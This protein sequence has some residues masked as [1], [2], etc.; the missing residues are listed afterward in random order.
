MRMTVLNYI[1]FAIAAIIVVYE[2]ILAWRRHQRREEYSR[3][4]RRLLKLVREIIDMAY[5][6]NNAPEKFYCKCL[7]KISASSL[8]ARGIIDP[9]R[10]LR[11]TRRNLFPGNSRREDAVLLMLLR[12]GFTPREL[13]VVYGL[14]S[15]DSVYVKISRLRRRL[16]KRMRKELEKENN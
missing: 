13:K 14:K 16:D 1:G 2:V 8:D 15:I 12:A 9:D 5:V 11:P 7:E 10:L 6:D 3:Q 4:A